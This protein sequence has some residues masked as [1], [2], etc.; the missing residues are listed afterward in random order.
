MSVIAAAAPRTVITLTED[1]PYFLGGR[2]A[3]LRG[4]LSLASRDVTIK[5]DAGVHPV[6]RF[7]VDAQPGDM[8]MPALLPFVGG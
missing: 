5:A 2:A 4:S 7:A 6:L 8:R 1:G 3:A